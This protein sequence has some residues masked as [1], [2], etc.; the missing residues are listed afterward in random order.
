MTAYHI[1]IN[2]QV[3]G[4]GFR[5]FV[6]KLAE[7]MCIHGWVNNSNDGVHIE[8]NA[9][10]GI[11]AQFYHMIIENSPPHAIITNH[12]IHEV[13]SKVF[14]SFIIKESIATAKPN[15]LLTP[16]I[17]LCSKCRKEILENNNRWFNYPFTTCLHCGPRYSIITRLPYDRENTTMAPLGLCQ[18][19]LEEYH[20]VY[21]RRH[22]SQTISC[23]QCAIPMHLYNAAG[24]E[25]SNNSKPIL[26]T[27]NDLLKEGNIIAVK[28]I[29]GYL[30]LC[31]AANEF[32][33]STLRK[34]KHRPAK[35]FALLYPNIDM[36][37]ADAELHRIE[38]E[39]LQDK[40]APIVLCRLKDA[41]MATGSENNI[42][43]DLIAP[44]LNKIGVM[45][46]YT[47]L[48]LLM[49][50]AFGKPLIA[51]S[52]NI[53]GSP[54]IYKDSDA[55]ASLNTIADYILTYD[56]EIVV[57]QDDSVVQFTTTGQKII[58]RRSRGLAPNYYPNPFKYSNESVLAM[59]GELK[60]SFAMLNHHNLYVSQ[61]LGDQESVES[62]TAYTE[63]VDH[64]LELL[65]AK[66]GRILIDKHPGYFVSSLGKEK[67]ILENI[68]VSSIQHHKAHFGAVL[69]ENNLLQ[70]EEPVLGIIWDGT[71][72]GE[73]EQ[74]WGGEVFT[75]E[76][77]DMHRVA[78]LD[79]FT[80]MLGDKMSKEP[81]LAALS[82]LKNFPA[83]QK[84]IEKHF[85]EEEWKYY[86]KEIH[87][88]HQLL[89][90]S[91]GRLLDGL[92]SI[93]GICQIN[94]YEGEA[95][96]KLEALAWKHRHSSFEYY[97]LP[98][99]NRRLDQSV[100]LSYILTDLEE[101]KETSFIAWKI[102]CSLAKAIDNIS[103]YFSVKKIA[104]SGG[105]FQNELL[106][107]LIIELLSQKNEIYFHHQLSPNDECIGFGQIACYELFKRSMQ[108]NSE[109]KKIKHAVHEQ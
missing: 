43:T 56:R 57:P 44:G 84:I 49:A 8:F 61:Y 14:S 36:I 4:V 26:S 72:Y 51:T 107:E 75:Y 104:F 20:D 62:Q 98:L 54:I 65:Q 30:L 3:Q 13:P 71:G 42:C 77:G 5:P 27:I 2:G 79:Y 35:P 105:V 106:T 58:L 94:S 86:E 33:I 21:N 97:P 9:S 45:L 11:A 92:S 50:N 22:Y 67:A 99:I 53:S 32:S 69:A 83:K 95:A 109:S 82:L 15:L 1:H 91:M 47:P 73:D 100:M 78:H 103:E 102:F 88:P 19:C 68:P 52:G 60:S 90:S 6:Y 38:Y 41:P 64:L 31:D 59:G 87:H 24:D 28:G 81:R 96:M 39:A 108:R 93:L 63:T 12:H 10:P 7:K 29:G 25:L 85:T 89:T 48:L 70:T 40:S 23:T 46:P 74:I 66:A 37:R 101:K 80:Q 34:R 55:L 16:D 18:A 17:A 76:D